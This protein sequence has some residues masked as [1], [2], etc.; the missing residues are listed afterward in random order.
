VHNFIDFRDFIVRKG[1]IRSYTGEEMII[2]FNMHDGLLFCKGK[3]NSE[4]NYSAP[5]GAGRVYSRAKAK[6]IIDVEKFKDSMK[7]IYSTSVGFNTLD[8][9]PEAYKNSKM[10]EE[11]IEPTAEIIMRVKPVMNMKDAKGDRE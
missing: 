5:H 2:P 9:A 7:D 3:S 8:E 6:Q 11:A 1:A 4:W 10:I